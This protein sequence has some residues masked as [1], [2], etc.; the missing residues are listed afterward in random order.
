MGYWTDGGL[1]IGVFGLGKSGRAAIDLL[2]G[3][4]FTVIGF[5][6]NPNINVPKKCHSFFS[7][8]SI[9]AGLKEIDGLVLSPGMDP[10]SQLITEVREF[11]IPVIGEIELA[12]RNSNALI[13]AVT[14]S[15]GK[16]TTSEWLGYTLRKAGINA[17]VAGNTGYAFSRALVEKPDSD[18]FV[19]EISSYQLQTIEE[20]RPEGAVVLNITPDHLDRHGNFENYRDAKAQIFMN[21][22]ENDLLVLN[23]DDPA[24]IQLSGRGAGLEMWFSVKGMVRTGAC[25]VNGSVLYLDDTGQYP[26]MPIDEISLRGEHN[27]AN[28]LAVVCLGI[29][30]GLEPTQMIDG[31]STFGGVPHRIE[32]IRVHNGIEYLNDSKSTN[33]ESLIVALKSCRKPVILIAGGKAKKADY[34]GLRELISEKTKA[35]I[36]IGDASDEL[37]DSWHGS[38]PIYLE[39]ELERAVKKASQLASS[40]EIVLLSPGCASFDQY[41]N[42]E[43]RGEHFRTIVER[44]Q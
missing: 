7:G 25:A 8:D 15:N 27:L 32:L 4:G 37:R 28:A 34:S 22:F 1:K 31:L 26:V 43:E 11:G 17:C 16:T 10:F 21:Q 6:S 3:K 18:V 41:G 23:E 14:G 12:Y 38:T 9:A 24:S 42:F 44:L 5:D 13:L 36:L 29:K 20:F 30:A 40:G 39:G 19:L 35:V 33:P 2:Y